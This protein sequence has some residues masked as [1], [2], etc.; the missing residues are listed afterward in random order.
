MISIYFIGEIKDFKKEMLNHIRN[1]E[2]THA[3]MQKLQNKKRF[4]QIQRDAARVKQKIRNADK[5]NKS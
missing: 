3:K 2:D 5:S 4:E 1:V